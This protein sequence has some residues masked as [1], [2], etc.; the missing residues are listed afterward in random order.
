MLLQSKTLKLLNNF[1]QSI[2]LSN[3][4]EQMKSI[5]NALF[6]LGIDSIAEIYVT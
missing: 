6:T 1:G 5:D 4:L 3:I 2:N